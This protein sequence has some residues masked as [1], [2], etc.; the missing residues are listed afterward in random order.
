VDVTSVAKELAPDRR[1]LHNDFALLPRR[2]ALY[3]CMLSSSVL[4]SISANTTVNRV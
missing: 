1:N 3:A 2:S 4:H